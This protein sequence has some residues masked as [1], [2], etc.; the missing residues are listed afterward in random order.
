MPLEALEA[1]LDANRGGVWFL[2]THAEAKAVQSVAKRNG[3]AFFHID[4]KNI[5]RKEQLLNH[6]ATALR[7]PKDFGHNWDALE[8][9]LTDLEWVDADGYVIYYDHIDGLL[10]AHPDQVETLVEILRDAVASWKEDDT[11]MVV[12]LSGEKSPKGVGKLKAKDED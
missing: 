12:L 6:V 2:P 4:G 5:G 7:F 10:N 9:C 3:Y 1:L 8:E 11:A